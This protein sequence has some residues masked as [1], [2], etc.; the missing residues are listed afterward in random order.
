MLYTT[1]NVISYH[2]KKY[3]LTKQH[4]IVLETKFISKYLVF[5]IHITILHFTPIYFLLSDSSKLHGTPP[6]R[7]RYEV[8]SRY[9]T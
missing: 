1:Y 8:S 5:T 7:Y 4:H 6:A 9:N 3:L 2:E